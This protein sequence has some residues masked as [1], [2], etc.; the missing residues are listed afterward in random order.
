MS[1]TIWTQ[2]YMLRP[3]AHCSGGCWSL[4]LVLNRIFSKFVWGRELN[5]LNMWSYLTYV[6]TIAGILKMTNFREWDHIIQFF[7]SSRLIFLWLQNCIW[8]GYSIPPP[9]LIHCPYL[10]NIAG[11]GLR[12]T[13]A[14]RYQE[15]NEIID[16][17][18]NKIFLIFPIKWS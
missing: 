9:N 5:N 14:C 11:V 18:R 6:I 3:V 16:F 15:L 7:R 2:K 8:T 12:I 17:E 10:L 13:W 4:C 1:T